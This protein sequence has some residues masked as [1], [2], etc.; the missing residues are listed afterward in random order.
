[1]GQKFLKAEVTEGSTPRTL[2]QRSFWRTLALSV[3]GVLLFVLQYVVSLARGSTF[4]PGAYAPWA[5][6]G[7]VIGEDALLNWP[8]EALLSWHIQ[9]P[10]LSLMWLAA[11]QTGDSAVTV[12]QLVWF[13]MMAASV[14]L[15]V[16]VFVELGA[17]NLWSASAGAVYS[18]TPSIVNYAFWSYVPT[19]LFF[20]SNLAVLGIALISRRPVLG[21]A[22]SG[23]GAVGLFLTRG[24]YFWIAVILWIVIASALA[25]KRLPRQ[26]RIYAL[27]IST[28]LVALVLSMQ[29]HRFIQFNTWTMTSWG[30]GSLL[31]TA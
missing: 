6:W 18:L 12:V 31:R 17:S 20:F 27:L 29:G 1:M 22:V 16:G 23:L 11:L 30:S 5:G 7:Y 24:T 10:G 28:C 13:V 2:W 3:P 8:I 14:M 21:L 19:P 4:D 26:R 25:I 9:T 15:L